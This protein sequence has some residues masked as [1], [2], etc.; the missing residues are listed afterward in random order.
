MSVAEAGQVGGYPGGN[1][2]AY[3]QGEVPG[4]GPASGLYLPCFPGQFGSMKGVNAKAC[5]DDYYEMKIGPRNTGEHL[6][7]ESVWIWNS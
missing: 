4:P 6:T 1:Q 2:P 7:E 5:M 3:Q